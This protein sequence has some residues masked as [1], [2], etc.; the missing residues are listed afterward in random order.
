MRRWASIT[1][2]GAGAI[3]ERWD[4]E[5]IGG[6][7][8]NWSNWGGFCVH[9]AGPGISSLVRCGA[10]MRIPLLRH[11]GGIFPVASDPDPRIPCDD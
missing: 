5:A 2:I 3:R 9:P 11:P 10:M 1:A 4:D 6:S 8:I 7:L